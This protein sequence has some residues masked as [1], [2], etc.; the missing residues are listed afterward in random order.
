[1][2]EDHEQGFQAREDRHAEPRDGI[3]GPLSWT[4]R[5]DTMLRGHA[6]VCALVHRLA[7]MTHPS[8]RQSFFWKPP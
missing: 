3:H 1:M 7:R 8:C 5:V 2:P 6:T 4:V